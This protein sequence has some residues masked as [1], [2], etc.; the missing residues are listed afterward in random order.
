MT[1]INTFLQRSK[2]RENNH[3]IYMVFA[4]YTLSI[5][6]LF[7][8]SDTFYNI[9]S[10]ADGLNLSNEVNHTYDRTDDKSENYFALSKL[11]SQQKYIEKYE[12]GYIQTNHEEALA[13]EPDDTY[14]LM[15]FAMNEEEYMSMIDH[16]EHAEVFEEDLNEET[17]SG[18]SSSSSSLDSTATISTTKEEIEMLERI[19][20]AEATGEDIK[21]KILVANVIFNR[22]EAEEFPDTIEE[23]I[24]QKDGGKYQFSPISDKRFWKVK[25]TKETK[26]A[27]SR[28]LE[29]EDYSQGALFFMARKRAKKSNAKWFDENLDWLFKY[30]GHE[31]FK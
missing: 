28:V 21:G 3:G 6:L 8:G 2:L 30:G 26:E 17:I 11:T 22:I 19:V 29:G 31:F 4:A 5:L 14:W 12:K 1:S 16:M 9:K 25:V 7:I 27:V 13:E 15:G 20:E 10:K 23:V 24:F 18:F